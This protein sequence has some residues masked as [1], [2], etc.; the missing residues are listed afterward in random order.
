MSL[1]LPAP[2]IIRT[3]T[4]ADLDAVL[5][6]DRLSFPSPTKAS[7]YRYELTQNKLAH[8]CCLLA[9]DDVI[10]YAGYWVLADELHIS[11]IAIHPDRRGCGLGELLLLALL[12]QAY[13]QP[14]TLVTLEVRRSNTTARTLYRKYKLDVVGERPRYYKDTGEDALIMT[15]A[16]LDAPYFNWLQ[17]RQAALF[18]RL[19]GEP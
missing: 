6:I 5:T 4:P 19:R 9:H 11:T 16:P 14:V 2:Y 15:R 3:M 13:Q 10:G 7:L 8:Y 18:K 12:L 17:T 1:T